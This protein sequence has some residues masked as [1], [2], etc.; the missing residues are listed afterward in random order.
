MA[1]DT[2]LRLE[3]L[4]A[5]LTICK[6]ADASCVDLGAI[7]APMFFA[8]TSDEVSL[9]CPTDSLPSSTPCV[10]REDGWRALR[11]VGTLDFSL[12]GIIAGISS[13]LADSGVPVFC[14]STYD[15]D[16]VLVKENCFERT[17]CVLEAAGYA[18]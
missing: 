1:E 10:A 7:A 2:S 16:Y 5:P 9:V 15:T 3:V 12:T 14:V 13:V 8:R 18:L 4:E 6:V 11:V 17:L